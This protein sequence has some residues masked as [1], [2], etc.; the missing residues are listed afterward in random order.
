MA[1]VFHELATNAAKF[2]ALSSADGHV[3]VRWSHKRNGHAHSWLSIHW[4][5]RGGPKRGAKDSV[6]IWHQRDS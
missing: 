4:E 2:G 5:E 3:C 1:M 6:R